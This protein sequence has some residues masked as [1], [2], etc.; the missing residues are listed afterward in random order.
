MGLTSSSQM[1]CSGS[2]PLQAEQSAFFS[3]Y[4]NIKNQMF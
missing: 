3:F 2:K 1:E 4:E